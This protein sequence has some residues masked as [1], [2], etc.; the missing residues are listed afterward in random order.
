MKKD[1]LYEVISK[2][3]RF[4]I[5]SKLLDVS[6]IGDTVSAEK[7]I[8]TFFAPTDDAFN[9]L[10]ERALKLL[11]SPEGKALAAAILKQHLIPK[12]YLYANDLR[13]QDSVKTMNGSKLKIEERTNVLHL[14]DAHVLTPGIAAANGVVF[15]IDKVLPAKYETV[16]AKNS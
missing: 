14:E 13:R 8:F 7:E 5:L 15:P 6:G 12:S 4:T 11:V 9:S 10:S 3:E 1:S 2:D 16:L